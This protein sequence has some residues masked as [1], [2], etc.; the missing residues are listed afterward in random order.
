MQRGKQCASNRFVD[1]TT[2]AIFYAAGLLSLSTVVE[3]DGKR[4]N[5]DSCFEDVRA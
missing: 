5:V 4:D 2:I 1:F 3:L